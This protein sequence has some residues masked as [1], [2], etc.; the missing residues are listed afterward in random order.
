ER[1][2]GDRLARFLGAPH[3]L[4][5]PLVEAARVSEAGDLVPPGLAAEAVQLEPRAQRRA[6]RAGGGAHQRT[7]LG[8]PALAPSREQVQRAHALAAAVERH[9]HGLAQVP[10]RALPVAARTPGLEL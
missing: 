10:G 4:D 1:D 7:L 5:E 3:L 9:A 6:E 2:D 8:T